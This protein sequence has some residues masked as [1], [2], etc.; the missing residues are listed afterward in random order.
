MGF[1]EKLGLVT[2]ERSDDSALVGNT[3]S[4]MQYSEDLPDVSIDQV[5]SDNPINDIYANAGI[6]GDN[7]IYKIKDFMS[8]LPA[9]MTT[10]KKA[11]SISGILT[12]SGIRIDDLIS[13]GQ[14]RMDVLHSARN[15][16]D[17]N[18]TNVIAEAEADIEQLKG[19]IEAAEKRIAESRENTEKLL[20]AI[21]SEIDELDQLIKFSNTVSDV[22]KGG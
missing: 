13:D 15:R 8:A 5:S 14:H 17:S 10:A 20:S 7:S 18:N 4:Q 11:T 6:N 9:E 2:E 16:A 21:D 3:D 22:S 1:L 12:V 19:L